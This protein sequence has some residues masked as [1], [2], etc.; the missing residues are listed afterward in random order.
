MQIYDWEMV[1]YNK[2]KRLF[3]NIQYYISIYVIL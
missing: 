1:N 3:T 2:F